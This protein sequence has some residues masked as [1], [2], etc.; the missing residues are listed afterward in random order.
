MYG[1]QLKALAPCVL[2]FVLAAIGFWIWMVIDCAT[3]EPSQGNDKIV[4][5]L[6]LIFTG[7]IGALI[8]FFARRPLRGS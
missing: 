5:M 6:V 3:N 4:W 8:Y 7:W 1:L 2:L